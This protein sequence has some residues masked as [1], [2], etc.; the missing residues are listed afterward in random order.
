ML[1]HL[2]YLK[3]DYTLPHCPICEDH[4]P[5]EMYRTHGIFYQFINCIYIPILCFVGGLNILD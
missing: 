3:C 1:H 2:Y 5:P 4:Q